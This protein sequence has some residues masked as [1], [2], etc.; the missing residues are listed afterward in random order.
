VDARWLGLHLA[1]GH[2]GTCAS[3][4]GKVPTNVY[5]RRLHNFALDMKWL[6]WPDD[7]LIR[8]GFRQGHG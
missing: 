1:G 4:V 5:L 3:S 8:S 7:S 6:P 2:L